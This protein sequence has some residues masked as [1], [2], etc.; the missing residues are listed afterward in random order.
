MMNRLITVGYIKL[1]V[2]QLVFIALVCFIL[3]MI[4][5]KKNAY[6]ALLGGMICAIPGCVFAINVFK[7]RGARVAKQILARMY[8]G[9]AL[10]L[11]LTFVLFTVVFVFIPIAAVPFFLTFIITQLLHWL[12]PLVIGLKR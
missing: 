6:S 2:I 10:K 11:G 8:W 9:E 4:A 12:A 7:Y 3:I 1:L 5:D